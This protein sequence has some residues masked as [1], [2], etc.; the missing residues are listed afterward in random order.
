MRT[1]ERDDLSRFLVHLTR[2]YSGD[3]AEKNLISMLRAERIEARNPYCLFQPKF[4][5]LHFSDV[6]KK[7]FNSVCFTEVP[8]SQLRH[9]AAEIQGRQIKLKPYGLVFVKE[10]LLKKGASPALYINAKGT[11]LKD[12]LIAQFD[13]HFSTRD[14]YQ[15]LKKDFGAKADSIIHYYSLINVISDTHDFSWE[16]EWRHPGDLEFELIQ[17]SAILVKDPDAFVERCEKEFSGAALK[18]ILRVP[19]ISPHWNVEQIIE[20]LSVALWNAK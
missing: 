13:Q 15:K 12:H 18:R 20:I 3:S 14:Q 11:S 10:D 8:F 19:I 4:K 16:R 2:D 9:L 17:L 5:H 7:K 1:P 6:L